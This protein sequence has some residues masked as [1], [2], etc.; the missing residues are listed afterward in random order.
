M[1][2]RICRPV[3]F[4]EE[5]GVTVNVALGDGD[6]LAGVSVRRHPVITKAGT[7]ITISSASKDDGKVP[8]LF[9]WDLKVRIKTKRVAM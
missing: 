6:K 9:D 7:T 3:F 4:V 5:S 8:W 1:S 2:E